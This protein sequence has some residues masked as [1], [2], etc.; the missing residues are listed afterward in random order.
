MERLRNRIV[1]G[2][3]GAATGLAGLASLTRCPGGAC[4]SC[5]SCFGAGAGILLLAVI[6]KATTG[7]EKHDGV[8]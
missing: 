8:A 1:Y 3:V 6:N 2:A 5:L 4:G 7:K